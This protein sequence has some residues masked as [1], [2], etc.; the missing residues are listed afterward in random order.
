V[1]QNSGLAS[2]LLVVLTVLAYFP[3]QKCKKHSI[4]VVRLSWLEETVKTGVR[5]PYAAHALQAFTGITL[6]TTG[7]FETEG[8][9]LLR[10][11]PLA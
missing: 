3:G 6:T 5:Q 1:P 4:P 11:K 8:A 9:L 10:G 2:N 7:I